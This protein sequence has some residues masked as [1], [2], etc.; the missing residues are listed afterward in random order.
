MLYV[1]FFLS[2]LLLGTVLMHL[3]SLLFGCKPKIRAP[4]V[5]LCLLINSASAMVVLTP[6]D[7]FSF[8]ARLVIMLLCYLI[9]IAVYQIIF[10]QI[11]LKI[12]YVCILSYITNTFYEL[13]LSAFFSNTIALSIC[14]FI[15][16]AVFGLLIIAVIKRK[17]SEQFVAESLRI[18][19]KRLY[20]IVMVFLYVFTM[21]TFLSAHSEKDI[22][23]RKVANVLMMP[24]IVF[25]V[26]ILY[27]LVN[28]VIKEQNQKNISQLL[29]MH[30][31]NQIEY[32]EKV[33]ERYT[34]IRRLNHDFKN[35]L[36]CLRSLIG[37]NENQKAL[38]YIDDVEKMIAS[39]KLNYDTG[40]II[41]DIILNN[42]SSDAEQCNA[43]IV[44]D[45][46]IPSSGIANAD[47]CVIIANALDNAVEACAKD[48]TNSEK[49]ISVNSV[50]KQGY[51]ILRV[52]NPVFEHVEIKDKY[53]MKT[54]KSDKSH[55]GFGV[56]NMISI[57]EK[58]N[59]GV[60]ISSD[61]KSFILEATLLLK[62]EGV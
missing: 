51:F 35:H 4:F 11:K 28:I 32:Y 33:N 18:I 5:I 14:A 48:E 56:A 9:R 7:M 38:M 10:R 53:N 21:F 6:A 34:T 25:I 2:N 45:G 46:V 8:E 54:T 42:K 44:F 3:M 22:L 30:L 12:V 40:N 17:D 20:V 1:G 52:V 50:F 55:H 41:A 37:E 23:F 62:Q 49:T 47:L 58:Y 39:R 60:H 59:G 16:E 29:S 13:L 24:T 31:E 43:K 15:I 26:L 36:L 61:D 57:S 19:P 27:W